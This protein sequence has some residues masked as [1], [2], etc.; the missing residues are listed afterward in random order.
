MLNKRALKRRNLSFVV[1][2]V[3]CFGEGV[4]FA[5]QNFTRGVLRHPPMWSFGHLVTVS[6]K[7]STMQV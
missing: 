3:T 6:R 1:M 5:K 7:G 4:N 2:P